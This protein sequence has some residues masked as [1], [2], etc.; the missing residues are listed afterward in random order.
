MTL[1]IIILNYNVKYYLELC[2]QSVKKATRNIDAEV[3]VIDNASIDGSL[4]MIKQ[5]YPEVIR[6]KNT[7]NVG[8][9]KAN[10]QGV[11]IAQGEYIC[12]LNPDM[13][14]AENCF[15]EVIAF[16]KAKKNPG[17]IGV[18]LIDG[19]GRFL[20]ESK[21]NLPTPKVALSKMMGRE[22]AYYATYLDE[23]ARGKVEVLVGA[24]MFMK[25]STYLQMGGFD[26]DYFMYGE[27]IDLSYRLEQASF[28]NYYLGDLTCIHFKG[29]ST[30]RNREYLNRFYNAMAVFYGKH[31]SSNKLELFFV[32]SILKVA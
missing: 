12:I 2:L 13:V 11:A 6:I 15:E 30:N 31:F 19:S 29:E 7:E 9:A 17:A 1:S 24:F 14:V 3:I 10:N 20:P 25:K 22:K 16:A 27:D 4:E 8:F 26:E 18:K 23:N 21:R 28:T 32:R 5:K